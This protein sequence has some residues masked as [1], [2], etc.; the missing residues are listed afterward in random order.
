MA[1][2]NTPNEITQKHLVR[3]FKDVKRLKIDDHRF[4]FLIG[5]G[6]SKSSG[7][8][9]GWELSKD[10]YDDLKD[11]LKDDPDIEKW[12]HKIGVPFDSVNAG[13]FYPILYKKRYEPA[14]PIGYKEFQC[15]MENKEPSIGYVI[16]SNILVEEK[17]NF[18]ITT[19]FDYLIEDAV[20]SFST[21]KPFIVGH[22]ALAKFIYS[23][24]ERPTILKVHRDLFLQP[25]NDN[26]QTSE[27][28][29]EW[30][31]ALS[32]VLKNFYLLV[33]GYGG[34][35]GSLMDYLQGIQPN[36][37]QPIYWCKRNKSKLNDKINKLLTK[38]DFIVTIDGF[39]ELMYALY[40]AL[41]YKLFEKLDKPDEHPYILTAKKKIETLEVERKKIDERI[42][43][44]KNDNVRIEENVININVINIKDN[45]EVVSENELS[46]M[47]GVSS[48][49][50]FTAYLEKDK[51]KKKNIY[52]KGIE[53]YPNDVDLLV[54][55][56]SFLLDNN[57]VK[58]A[59]EYYKKA[60]DIEP[61]NHIA[62]YNWGTS[63]VGLANSKT[64]NEAETL[65]KQALNKYKKA[66]EIKPNYNAA[67][68]N[69]GSVLGIKALTKTGVEAE[70]FF[71]QAFE[72][73]KK[74]IEIKSDDHIALSNWGVYL[75]N[76]ANTKTGQEADN[77]YFQAFEKFQRAIEIQPNYH[78]AYNNWGVS[79]K[80]LAITKKGKEA[81]ILFNQAI[82]KCE[83]A[84]KYGGNSYNLTRIYALK[85][86][87]ENAL[88][89]LEKSLKNN[90]IGVDHVSKD[91][92]WDNYKKDKDFKAL[93]EKYK[94]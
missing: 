51:V 66:I 93:L 39:D 48:F 74:A 14:P 18:V 41:D 33:V 89:Y 54:D 12:K 42:I 6:A 56:A 86:D 81:E 72:K 69:L 1:I 77:L 94:N 71:E 30:K 91:S 53:K 80:K 17:H 61:D 21:T 67:L 92:D 37:R 84:I 76:K 2:N 5:A 47:K 19:N 90:D 27:L 82:E 10:W 57:E 45:K 20:R 65:Y 68:A 8:P 38:K 9:T 31:K 59:E 62:Y 24:T 36:N 87:K 88:I 78:I 55:F 85:Q 79:L 50:L 15:L 73:F 49:Y 75:D 60:L 29:E 26:E 52:E 11:E 3:I 43:Q 7:I 35:D 40:G 22:E 23:Q 64:G 34:N 46:I 28:K 13:R 32:P 70:D 63:L 44:D 4:C 83:K 25:F 58:K 16:L